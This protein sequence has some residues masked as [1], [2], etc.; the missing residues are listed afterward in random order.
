MPSLHLRRFAARARVLAAAAALFA[1]VS[2]LAQAATYNITTLAEDTVNNGNCTL[3]E[4]L[5]A[6]STDSTNDLC[7]GDVGPDTIVLQAVGTYSLLAGPIASANRQLTIRGDGAQ[8]RTSYVVNLGGA[9]RLLY[10]LGNS[11]LTLENFTVINGFVAAQ[12]GVV[13]AEDSDLTLRRMAIKFSGATDGG[14]VAF[15]S[16]GGK[17]LDVA[18]AS[19]EQNSIQAGQSEGGGL[20]IDLQAGGTVRVVASS[21]LSNEI[22]R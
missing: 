20:F 7:I 4:A 5:L 13:L 3:R 21:F 1:L 14:G 8:S 10:V 16:H 22:S 9:Q 12:G 17:T 19:F 2:G 6:A 11:S 15:I 18:E